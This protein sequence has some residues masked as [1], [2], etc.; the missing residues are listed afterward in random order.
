MVLFG[1]SKIAKSKMCVQMFSFFLKES[2]V[3]KTYYCRE[4]AGQ[5]VG[6]QAGCSLMICRLYIFIFD[7]QIY[8]ISAFTPA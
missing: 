4:F 7:S 3:F 6:S 1:S 2:N 5:Q 8:R